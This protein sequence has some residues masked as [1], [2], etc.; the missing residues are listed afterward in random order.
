MGKAA[1]EMRPIPVDA[2]LHG[3]IINQ[4]NG[5]GLH[6]DVDDYVRDAIRRAFRRG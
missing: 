6:V 2:E 3:Q 4:I 5:N 1:Q